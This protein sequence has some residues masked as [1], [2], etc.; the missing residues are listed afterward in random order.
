MENFDYL[1][2]NG[3][4]LRLF[5]AVY[6]SGSVNG[7]TEQLGLNQST[8]S[9]NLDKLR[10]AFNDP[11]FV[12]AGRGIIPTERARTLAP[13]IRELVVQLELLATKS[14]YVP[15]EDKEPVSIAA[16]V[17]ELL[18]Y[19]KALHKELSRVMGNTSVRFLEL[20]SRDNVNHLLDTQA[21]DMVISVRPTEL[22]RSFNSKPIFSF[23]QVCYFDGNV[24]GPIGSV[25]DYCKAE[26]AALDFG[27]ETKSTVDYTLAA[28]SM[29]RTIK[30]KAPNIMALAQLM[31]GTP[32]ITTMQIDLANHAM[33]KLDYCVAPLPLPMV[34]IDLVWHR[35]TEY[36]GRN[37]WLR[38]QILTTL[39]SY[40][41]H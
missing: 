36:S 40:R 9:Y 11:L 29:Y 15:S 31:E 10:D 16:N 12:K 39:Q 27:G 37:I 32:M 22:N 30:L 5:L 34:N 25:E 38:N 26:H 8:I 1:N 13:R 6:E 23:E 19:I 4:L 24:R 21:V 41:H 14:E 7:A 3:R 2:L 17:M 33:S 35:R 18:P 28:M 20:G